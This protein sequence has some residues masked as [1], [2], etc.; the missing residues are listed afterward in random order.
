[1]NRQE[2]IEFILDHFENPR[3][4]GA[5][6]DAD[7]HVE[8]GNPGCGDIVTMY[9]KVDPGTG[10]AE[11]TFEGTGCTISQ[12]SASYLS[13]EVTGKTL[14]EILAIDYNDLM[15]ALGKEIVEQRTRCA[16]L[17]LDTLRAA[18]RKYERERLLQPER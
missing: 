16:T 18:I 2:Q 10:K 3:R 9:L 17:S 13:E 4:K 6:P 11:V 14:A 7:A 12:A 8:G 15:D 5:L 1:M